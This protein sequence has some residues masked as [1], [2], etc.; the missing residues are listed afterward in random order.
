MAIF[1]HVRPNLRKMRIFL[2]KCELG[3][4]LGPNVYGAL[5]AGPHPKPTVLRYNSLTS[6]LCMK[7]LSKSGSKGRLV[8]GA[9]AVGFIY[10][11]AVVE[12]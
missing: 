7:C 6:Q 2:K 11:A 12:G 8:V 1:W 10:V 5:L 4:W 9:L 3:K